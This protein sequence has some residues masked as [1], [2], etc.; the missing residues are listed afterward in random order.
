MFKQTLKSVD[1]K[2]T[3]VTALVH[4]LKRLVHPGAVPITWLPVL[5]EWERD[6]TRVEG[7]NVHCQHAT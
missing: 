2:K 4:S 6:W 3:R 1:N 7:Y 5:L